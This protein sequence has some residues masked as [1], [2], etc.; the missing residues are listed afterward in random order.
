MYVNDNLV[1]VQLNWSDDDDELL[2]CTTGSCCIEVSSFPFNVVYI[3]VKS[4]IIITI[5]SR[6][7]KK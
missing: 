5:N 6:K 4:M 3:L 1:P 7:W 2:Y